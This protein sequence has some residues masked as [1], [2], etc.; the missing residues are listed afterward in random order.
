MHSVPFAVWAVALGLLPA[1]RADDGAAALALVDKAVRSHGGEANLARC[2]AVTA[3]MKGTFYGLGLKAPFT[4]EFAAQGADRQRVVFEAEACGQ[5]I[6][7]VHVLCGDKCWNKLGDE[8]EE[9]DADGVADAREEA[10]AEWV[11]TLVPLKAKAYTLTSLGEVRIDQRPAAGVRVSSK[12]HRDVSL[13]FDKETGL[14]VKTESRVKDEGGG[15]VTE[16]TFLGGY[17]DVQRTKQATTL[18]V[19]RDGA[20]Y[21]EAELSEIKLAE[22]LDDTVFAKP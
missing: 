10:H 9:L 15:E 16:E 14:L 7:F 6:R 18:T 21:L 5:A 3:K 22:K 17:Q 8:L 19:K 12:G 11:A 2:P 1:A 4:G 20:S 13:Y